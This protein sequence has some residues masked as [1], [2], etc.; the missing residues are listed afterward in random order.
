[1]KKNYLMFSEATGITMSDQGSDTS[2]PAR[3]LNFKFEE[4]GGSI[5][6]V[7]PEQG[8][9]Y[10]EPVF[11]IGKYASDVEPEPVGAGTFWSDPEPV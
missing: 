4:W 10:F 6:F 1:M 8:L 2:P 3:C 7:L 5:L 9:Q 11:V